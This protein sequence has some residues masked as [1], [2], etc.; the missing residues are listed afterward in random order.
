VSGGPYDTHTAATHAAAVGRIYSAAGDGYFESLDGGESWSSPEDG[1]HHR[2]LVGIGV[3]PRDPETVVVS[4][5]DGPFV[6]YRPESAEA[7]VYRRTG[8]RPWEQAMSGLPPAE[9]TTVSRFATHADVA[10][11]IYAAN[12]HGV[13]ESNDAGRS[14]RMLDVAWP[15]AALRSGVDALVCLPH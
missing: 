1:L 12:N 14:W 10:D 6:A 15:G 11:T 9:G 7:Y 13:F 3:E 8:R 4:A 5:A 2:Y